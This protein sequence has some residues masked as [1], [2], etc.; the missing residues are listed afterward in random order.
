MTRCRAR[1]RRWRG[2]WAGWR[3]LEHPDRWG[4]LVDVPPVLDDRAVARLCGVLAGCGEDQVA[5]RPAGVL[6]RRLVRAPLPR[7]AGRGWVPRGNG[8]GHRGDR[9]DRRA[10]GPVAGQARGAPGRA[11]QPVGSGRGGGGGAGGGLAAAGTAA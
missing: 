10:R 11:G 7:G 2:A 3:R 4:G 1:G 5:I 8:A 9:G 6:A